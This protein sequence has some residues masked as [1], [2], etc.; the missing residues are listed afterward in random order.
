MAHRR[1]RVVAACLLF[2]AG[3]TQITTTSSDGG[4]D[5]VRPEANPGEMAKHL[6]GRWKHGQHESWAFY[7]FREDGTYRHSQ[8]HDGGGG[9]EGM[10]T[11][12]KYKVLAGSIIEFTPEKGEVLR[13]TAELDENELLLKPDGGRWMRQ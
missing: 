7:T 2:L 3:C 9:R 6:V 1:V 4:G 8:H 10:H 12:G 11:E 5:A 13:Y